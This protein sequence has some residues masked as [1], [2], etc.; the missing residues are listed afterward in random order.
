[1]SARASRSGFLVPLC[2]GS[3]SCHGC[4]ARVSL[5]L[6]S[7]GLLGTESGSGVRAV[8]SSFISMCNVASQAD[9]DV[10]VTAA[11][12]HSPPSHA[13]WMAALCHSIRHCSSNHFKTS[14]QLMCPLL[15]QKR[16][17]RVREVQ[18]ARRLSLS[19][20][21]PAA[22]GRSPPAPE[23]KALG[24]LALAGCGRTG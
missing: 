4:T 15:S 12:E 24:P 22:P 3:G 14:H 6:A 21:P 1:M 18:T 16:H 7:H 8:S 17:S 2:L 13:W 23:I 5:L 10:T 19:P 9:A 20:F 11:E